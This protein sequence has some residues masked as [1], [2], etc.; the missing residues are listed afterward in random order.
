[1]TKQNVHSFKMLR[2]VVAHTIKN[3]KVEVGPW[4]YWH[5]RT[6]NRAPV[7]NNSSRLSYRTYRIFTSFKHCHFSE[8]VGVHS[9]SGGALFESQT[10]HQL[11]WKVVHSFLLS[12]YANLPSKSFSVHQSPCLST[13]HTDSVVKQHMER[14]KLLSYAHNFTPIKFDQHICVCGHY[15]V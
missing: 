12:L 13:L 8:R 9:N 2:V 1:M 10:G 5:R 11:S 4:V 14:Y 3:G 15:V 6:E 7:S